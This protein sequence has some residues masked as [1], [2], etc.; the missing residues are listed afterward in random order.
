MRK[1]PAPKPM[2]ERFMAKVSPEPNTGCWLWTAAS[3]GHGYGLISLSFSKNDLA[4]RTSWR[5]FH[6]PIPDGLWVLHKCD[7]PSCV[8]PA[9]LFLGTQTDNMI[10]ASEKKRI[11]VQK[12]DSCLH[13]HAYVGRNLAVTISSRNGR[14]FR[15]CRECYRLYSIAK[16]ARQKV[17]P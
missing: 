7:V 15:R 11:N 14:P 6:G 5:L 17:K 4:H 3:T 12:R 13:G 9:H 10:D 2:M 1:G 8:N 16:R